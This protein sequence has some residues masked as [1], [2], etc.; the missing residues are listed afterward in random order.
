MKFYFV[1]ICDVYSA[2]I[3]ATG[4]TPEETLDNA[5]K[6]YLK[7]TKRYNCPEPFTNKIAWL[8]YRGLSE[9]SCQERMI[10]DAWYE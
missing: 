1:S 7:Y 4:S 9:A 3:F 6:Q 2:N 10:G 5:W 8:K